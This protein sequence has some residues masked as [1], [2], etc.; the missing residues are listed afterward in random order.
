MAEPVTLATAK[1]YLRIVSDS[2]HDTKITAMIPRARAWV[3]DH[4][5]LVLVEREFI[6]Y[7]SAWGD[8]LTIYRRPI[9][10][11]AVSYA[12]GEDTPV[13]LDPEDITVL[14]NRYPLQIH[15]ASSWP[16]LPTGGEI[17]VTYTAGVATVD[18][19]LIGA[20]LALIEGEFAEG[21][22]YPE[23]AIEAAKRCC[24]YLHRPVMA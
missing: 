23:R 10:A 12:V 22:A 18:D 1:D 15:P 17:A 13:D 14:L 19:R 11:V 9:T 16:I 8:Y 6:E 4:V 5:G 2:G 24:A 20:I 7:F 21:Y 3:E